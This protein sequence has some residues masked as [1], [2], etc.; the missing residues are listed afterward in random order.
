MTLPQPVPVFDGH[1]DLL[2][3]LF[4]QDHADPVRIFL[5]GDGSG[6]LDLARCRKGG[7]AGGMF[8]VFVPSTVLSDPAD[9]TRD[10]AGRLPPPLSLPHAQAAT[11]KMA[12][13][14][15]QIAERAPQ[16]FKVCR[17]VAD[18]RAAMAA[19]QIAAVLHIEG[20]E[21]IAEDLTMLDV[22]HAAGLRS[23]GPVWS[24]PNI[25]GHGV[26]FRFNSTPDTGD[27]LTEA[28]KALV[29]R[30]NDLRILVDLSHLNEKGFWDVASIS[31]A[32]L[33]ATHSNVHALCPHARNL[34]ERQLHA[35]RDSDGM[36]GVNFA[37]A[38]L[39]ADGKTDPD[40]PLQEIVRHAE[41]LMEVVGE[42]R[43]G[44]GSDFDGAAIPA[45]MGDATGLPHLLAACSS[46]GFSDVLIEKLAWRNWLALLERTWGETASA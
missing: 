2:Y 41:A 11:V 18:I 29:R 37:T 6:H 8:A 15:L 9:L 24:R 39:R 4:T 25:F 13:L 35:I 23:I 10:K 27:G 5:D 34:T 3:R 12:A 28:G 32:P 26:P 46:A 42:D 30:C 22:L 43:V 16:D 19:G 38:F 31:R 20:A 36:V 7:F 40:T 21:A 44:L 33:V 17:S 1:N 14:L 45:A